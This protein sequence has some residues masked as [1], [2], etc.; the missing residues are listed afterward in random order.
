MLAGGGGAVR[1]PS[2]GPGVTGPTPEPIGILDPN[3]MDLY[4]DCHALHSPVRGGFRAAHG[5]V[6]VATRHVDDV[7]RRF[8]NLGQLRRHLLHARPCI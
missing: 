5:R 3:V 4:D 7:E 6:C 1:C 8:A 2:A